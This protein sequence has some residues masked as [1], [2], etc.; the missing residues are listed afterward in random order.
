MQCMQDDI[1]GVR[2]TSRTVGLNTFDQ[3]FK[4]SDAV[5]W[6]LAYFRMRER[7]Q[8]LDVLQSL[9]DL[10]IVK[11]TIEGVDRFEDRFTFYYFAE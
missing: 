1:F 2:T 4:G 5:V 10:G 7:S 6:T 9:L 11:C 8:A 3:C